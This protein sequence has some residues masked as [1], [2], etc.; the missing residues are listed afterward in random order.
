MKKI[1]RLTENDLARIV[2]RV[3]KES[4]EEYLDTD[5]TSNGNIV[6]FDYRREKNKE[7]IRRRLVSEDPNFERLVDNKTQFFT[8]LLYGYNRYN[9]KIVKV[10][11]DSKFGKNEG[12]SDIVIQYNCSDDKIEYDE[13][14]QPS[15][16][17][18]VSD[19]DWLGAWCNKIKWK[20]RIGKKKTIFMKNVST[21]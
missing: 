4:E 17:Q 10:R 21:N 6:T 15:Q 8:D 11:K 9:E 20:S 7:K 2:K 16:I 3:I 13:T 14:N 19:K 12:L 5:M 1:I 18:I